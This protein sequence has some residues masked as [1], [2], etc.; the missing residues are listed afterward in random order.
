MFGDLTVFH[1]KNVNN[2]IAVLSEK[3]RVMAVKEDIVPVGKNA[4]NL[5]S[6]VREILG[7]P[8]DVV[9]KTVKTVRCKWRML[10]VRL[11]AALGRFR[12]S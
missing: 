3:A 11:A 8:F 5:A 7:D 12:K 4:F 10:R 2:C 9:A 1:S 6:G